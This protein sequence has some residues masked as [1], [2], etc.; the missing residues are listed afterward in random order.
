MN[1]VMKVIRSSLLFEQLPMPFAFPLK[2]KRSTKEGF[3]NSKWIS[4]RLLKY[5]WPRE[6]LRLK[7]CQPIRNQNGDV[8]FSGLR[9]R[10][11][12]HWV[13]DL[14]NVIKIPEQKTA[15]QPAPTMALDFT[16]AISDAGSLFSSFSF[17]CL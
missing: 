14:N 1:S 13:S 17:G 8:I 7:G 12:I 15:I 5:K 16:K 10:I 9:V 3:T 6:V 11:G 2:F 4:T